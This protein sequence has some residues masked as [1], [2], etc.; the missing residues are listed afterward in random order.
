LA[1][2][3][4]DFARKDVA[5]VVEASGDRIAPEGVGAAKTLVD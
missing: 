2:D 4:L 5:G 1:G 3:Q